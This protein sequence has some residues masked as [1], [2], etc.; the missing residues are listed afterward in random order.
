MTRCG[1]IVKARVSL[2]L[3]RAGRTGAPVACFL[4]E[5]RQMFLKEAL[6]RCS[7]LE[8]EV[9][10]MYAELAACS[11][12][13]GEAAAAWSASANRERSHA[14]LLH[15][16]AELSVALGDDGPFLVQ[17]PVQLSTLRRVVESVRV[18]V[19]V[20]DGVD[21]PTAQLCGDMLDSALRTEL[22][23]GL[24]E[25]AEPEIKRVLRLIDEET[26]TARGHPSRSRQREDR[27]IRGACSSPV[28]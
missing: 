14:R 24:L 9:A 11:A 25:V 8:N 12:A 2:R 5:P 3:L 27:R 26:R 10:S 18:R 21:A 15:A 16:L 23:A 6:L 17:V 20:A 28:T 19:C 22:H 7:T 1:V 13:P 4:L